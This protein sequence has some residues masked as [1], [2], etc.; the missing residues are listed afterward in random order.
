MNFAPWLTLCCCCRDSLGAN[1]NRG[2]GLD[3]PL[4]AAAK[5]SNGELAR[6]LMD[7]GADIQAKN[8]EGKRPVELVPPENPLIQFFLQREGASPLPEPKP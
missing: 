5:A 8:A 1:V 3:S 7:F 4:H 2:R 6:L